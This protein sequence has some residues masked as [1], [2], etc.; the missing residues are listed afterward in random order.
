MSDYIEMLFR[1][2][3]KHPHIGSVQGRGYENNISS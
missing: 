2:A 3:G 1:R